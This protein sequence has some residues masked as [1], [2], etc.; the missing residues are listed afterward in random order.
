MHRTAALI[1]TIAVCALI[2]AA[3]CADDTQQPQAA[4]A[5]PAGQPQTTTALAQP[6]PTAEPQPAPQGDQTPT[7]STASAT[8]PSATAT[9]Q[10]TPPEPPLPPK[11]GILHPD[12]DSTLN[13]LLADMQAG[14]DPAGDGGAGAASQGRL[15]R[16]HHTRLEHSR[17]ALLPRSSTASAPA[18]PAK[19]G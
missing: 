3:G 19:D 16:R 12:L 11:P 6:I 10:S 17:R 9:A 18:M 13:H 4:E 2:L 7:A 15:R 14:A 5:P 1:L 8:L